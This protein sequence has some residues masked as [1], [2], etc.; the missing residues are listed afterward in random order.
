MPYS[1]KEKIFLKER[2]LDRL[3]FKRLYIEK[4]INKNNNN[5]VKLGDILDYKFIIENRS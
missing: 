1:N 3:K 5:I 4:L 2:S